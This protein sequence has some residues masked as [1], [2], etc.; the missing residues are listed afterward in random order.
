MNTRPL[1]TLRVHVA[2]TQNIGATPL[3]TRRTVRLR[4]GTF[5]GTG[6]QFENA[7]RPK[8]QPVAAPAG[9]HRSARTFER[10]SKPT[11]ARS[12]R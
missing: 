12:S 4:G 10:H 9:Q 3:G 2:A 5:E 1:M 11:T 8:E 7:V 6:L